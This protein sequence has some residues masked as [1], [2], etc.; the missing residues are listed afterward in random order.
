MKIALALEKFSKHAGG[1]ESYAVDLAADLVKRGWEVHLF[2]YEWD[3]SPMQAIFH[4]ISPPPFFIPPSL[5]L[6]RFALI[7]R[8]LCTAENF[9]VVVGF[10]ST[11]FMNVYQSHGGVHKLSSSRKLLAIRSPLIRFFK[12][13]LMFMTP[14]YHARSWIESAPFRM[15]P[16]PEIVAISDMIKADI[17]EVFGVGN[18]E[19]RVIYNGI[20]GSRFIKKDNR[21]DSD[22]LRKSLGFDDHTLFLFMSYDFRKKG[23]RFLIEA[24]ARLKDISDKKFGVVVV[25]RAPSPTLSN[26]VSRLGLEGTVVFPGSTKTPQLYYD[27]C[28]VFVLPTFYDACSLVV[29]EAMSSG[30]PVITSV[31]NG[32]SGIIDQGV[33]G[34]VLND[35][36]DSVQISDYMSRLMERS[37]LRDMSNRAFEKSK[38]FSIETNHQEMIR[39]FEHAA[40]HNRGALMI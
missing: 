17:M 16:R 6:I 26:M 39:V 9:D 2:G 15:R 37:V 28:D 23:V 5:R 24:A 20:D 21:V 31:F 35:P 33:D 11:V 30:L 8:R 40:E 10:G 25:G 34:F 27:A 4:K 18:H 38:K 1:A 36:S 14:K 19:I 22:G 13:L 3:G 32:A 29:F 7:H 12:K